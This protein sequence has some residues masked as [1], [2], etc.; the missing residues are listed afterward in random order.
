M[1]V[2]AR[3]KN[4][5]HDWIDQIHHFSAE[6]YS[7]FKH[8]AIWMYS[9]KKN[10]NVVLVCPHHTVQR[11]TTRSIPKSQT[12]RICQTKNC[13]DSLS[14]NENVI[15]MHPVDRFCKYNT[16]RTLKIRF[17]LLLLSLITCR[18]HRSPKTAKRDVLFRLRHNAGQSG[19]F[20]EWN[21][22]ITS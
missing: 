10:M 20:H 12:R 3:S 19:T 8:M 9:V 18:L 1:W 21:M 4:H 6:P 14:L 2:R 5:P 13:Q 11:A 22:T 17:H 7:H 16:T 15:N